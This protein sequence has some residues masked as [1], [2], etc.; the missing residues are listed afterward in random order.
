[1]TARDNFQAWFTTQINKLIS[2]RDAGLVIVMI[3]F[4]LLERYL[5]R[6]TAA[7]PKSP[8]FFRGLLDV[9]PELRT[10]TVAEK[11]WWNYRHGLLHNV[12]M[13]QANHGLTHDTIIVKI[14]T[15]GKVWL[16]PVL[17]AQRVLDTI[18]AD[19][20]VFEGGQPLPEVTAHSTELQSDGT[21]TIYMGTSTFPR[22][23]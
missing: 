18:R 5:R 6:R 15:D 4:P 14:E 20:E 22:K 16:N 12:T 11:F 8:R 3:I 1:M 23:G 7:E 21:Q 10:T 19:F 2:D 17:F 13:S 9:F